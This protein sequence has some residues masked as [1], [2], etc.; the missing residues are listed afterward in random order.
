MLRVDTSSDEAMPDGH[1]DPVRPSENVTLLRR[2]LTISGA[3][4]RVP[5]RFLYL[6]GSRKRHKML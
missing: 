6:Q 4:L 5:P 1:R 2:S 3:A